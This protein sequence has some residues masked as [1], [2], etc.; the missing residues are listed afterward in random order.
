LGKVLS[1]VSSRLFLFLR[2][3]LVWGQLAGGVDDIRQVQRRGLHRAAHANDPVRRECSGEVSLRIPETRVA[4]HEALQFSRLCEEPNSRGHTGFP[5]G[6]RQTVGC[7]GGATARVSRSVRRTEVGPCH[8][9]MSPSSGT[10][11]RAAFSGTLL[12]RTGFASTDRNPVRE[13]SSD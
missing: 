3:L 13:R 11:P 10:N 2:A 4:I 9:A 6:S 1:C 12:A 5:L 7:P 8:L